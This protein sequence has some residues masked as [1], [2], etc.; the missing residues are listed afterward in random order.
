MILSRL[1][2]F[3]ADTLDLESLVELSALAR[4]VSGEFDTLGVDL[5]DWLTANTKVLRRAIRARTADQ[6]E[7]LVAEKRAR[8][9]ATLPAEEKRAKLREELEA[10]EKKL[11]ATG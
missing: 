1:R 11:A 4:T 10:L 2:Q 5:P 8:L 7:K 3:D 9:E 6:L